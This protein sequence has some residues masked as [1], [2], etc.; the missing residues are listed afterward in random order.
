MYIASFN[1]N[2]DV[3]NFAARQANLQCLIFARFGANNFD[4]SAI[5]K[6]KLKADEAVQVYDVNSTN[7]D[8]LL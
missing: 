3:S 2:T 6:S 5:D 4:E 8:T 7:K 1:K